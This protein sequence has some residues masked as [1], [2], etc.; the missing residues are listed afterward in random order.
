MHL[1]KVSTWNVRSLTRNKYAKVQDYLES[2]NIAAAVL[3]ETWLD[4][5]ASPCLKYHTF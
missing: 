4:D 5:E 3:T 2:N 1:I